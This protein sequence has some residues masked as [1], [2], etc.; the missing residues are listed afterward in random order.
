MELKVL[1]YGAVRR[2]PPFPTPFNVAAKGQA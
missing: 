2:R 1:T